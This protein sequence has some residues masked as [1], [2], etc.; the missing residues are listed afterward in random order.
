MDAGT[1]QRNVFVDCRCVSIMNIKR[2]TLRTAVRV[3]ADKSKQYRNSN[4]RLSP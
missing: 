2:R 4:N 1:T 3:Y